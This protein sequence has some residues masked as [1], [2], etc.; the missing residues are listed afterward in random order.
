MKYR[1]PC[2]IYRA[3][4]RAKGRGGVRESVAPRGNYQTFGDVLPDAIVRE[5]GPKHIQWQ[6]DKQDTPNT[7]ENYVKRKVKKAQTKRAE[8]ETQTKDIDDGKTKDA[9]VSWE[10]RKHTI[11]AAVDEHSSD[12]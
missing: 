9:E 4:A 6:A 11:D 2:E 5:R 3:R 12:L 7:R 1:P 10:D 8:T